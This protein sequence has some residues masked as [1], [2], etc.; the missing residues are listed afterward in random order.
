MA[1]R[2]LL[3]VVLAVCVS[4]SV[5]AVRQVQTAEAAFHCIRIHAVMGGFN[6]NN[7]IQ[8][9][10]LR[11]EQAS[12]TLLTGHKIQFFNAGGTLM[13][14]FTFPSVATNGLTGDSILIA[15]SEFNSN[16]TGGAA[17]FVFSGANTTGP[18]A[19]H[20]V[21]LTG[22][23]VVW[24]NQA[25]DFNCAVGMPPSDSVAYG[26][27]LAQFGTAAAALPTTG[28]TQALRLSN[29][30]NPPVP[31]AVRNN[32]NDY[33][34]QNVATTTFPVS[35][36]A[37]TFLDSGSLPT[38]FTTPRNNGR[39]VLKLTAAAPPSVGGVAEQ[40]ATQAGAALA[41]DGGSD[42][43]RNEVA[44]GIALAAL[45]TAAGWYVYRRRATR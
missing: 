38:D 4:A 18:S 9:V 7:N 24:A 10:E 14:T 5:F 35:C 30:V 22:G 28:T 16:V 2:S 6:G 11:M 36:G 20:P 17:D 37:C 40:P 39:T 42:H 41:S 25:G 33:S 15:T 27:A 29:L 31:V 19:L 45:A 26:A 43:L 21:S 12:Q 8:Y 34:L 32:L 1:M 44:A 3:S 13:A 23:S